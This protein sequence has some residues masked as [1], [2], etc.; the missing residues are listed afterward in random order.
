MRKLLC[1]DFIIFKI[2]IK[3]IKCCTYLSGKVDE[4]NKG[5]VSSLAFSFN[6]IARFQLQST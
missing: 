2:H 3:I 6:S 1:V 5:A 4:V